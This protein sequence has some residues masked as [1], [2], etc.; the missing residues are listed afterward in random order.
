[1]DTGCTAPKKSPPP[2]HR[3]SY[4][5]LPQPRP[6]TPPFHQGITTAK[7]QETQ[8]LLTPLPRPPPAPPP[9]LNLQGTASSRAPGVRFWS[10]V[11]TVSG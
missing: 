2:H 4:P 6:H 7:R 11:Q 10:V 1:M 8:A 5:C 9:P 3:V